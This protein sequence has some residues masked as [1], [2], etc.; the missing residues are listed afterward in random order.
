[1]NI[2]TFDI[3]KELKSKDE[4]KQMLARL[5]RVKSMEE[6]EGLPL[7]NKIEEKI[8][9]KIKMYN[10]DEETYKKMKEERVMG[11]IEEGMANVKKGH[12]YILYI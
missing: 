8:R 12:R 4:K 5:F 3:L 9:Q 11:L 2:K 7:N 1:M 10:A 6:L